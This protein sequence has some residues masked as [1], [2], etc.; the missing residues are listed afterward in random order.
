[1]IEFSKVCFY[2][3]VIIMFYNKI[4]DVNGVQHKDLIDPDAIDEIIYDYDIQGKAG[5]EF[6]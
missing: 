1:M 5:N 3:L 6:I 4:Q 2:I